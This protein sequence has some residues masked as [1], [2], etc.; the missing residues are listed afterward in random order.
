VSGRS[1]AA[2]R[3]RQARSERASA[4]PE[5]SAAETSPRPRS[6]M[7]AAARER[8][9]DD[10]S[11]WG[12]GG[13]GGQ[14]V[15]Q[16]AEREGHLAV[17]AVGGASGGEQHQATARRGEHPERGAAGEGVEHLL[18]G[19]RLEVV[20][21]RGEERSLGG[22]Q[23]QRG[24]G[25]AGMASAEE[26]RDDQDAGVIA[27]P[28]VLAEERDAVAAGGG[29]AVPEHGE[30]GLEVGEQALDVVK[31]AGAMGGAR[32]APAHQVEGRADGVGGGDPDGAGARVVDGSG[33]WPRG[34]AAGERRP[35]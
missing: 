19:Q 5:A 20:G 1:R 8:G 7:V 29:R 15:E 30:G 26:A 4:A 34:R 17:V 23:Q 35:R 3:S 18:V 31:A 11:S 2:K 32:E 13:A 22:T 9:A 25:D 27:A 21:E 10:G 14:A 28:G 6:R 16:V 33:R 24:A 12:C